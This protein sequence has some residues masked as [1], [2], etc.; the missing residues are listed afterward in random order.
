MQQVNLVNFYYNSIIRA[1]ATQAQ[2][3]AANASWPGTI[4]SFMAPLPKRNPQFSFQTGQGWIICSETV[5]TN[6][7]EKT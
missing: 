4:D 2:K 5:P 6:E 1:D 3:K 7:Y